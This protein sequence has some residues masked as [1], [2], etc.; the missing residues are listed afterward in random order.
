MQGVCFNGNVS[1]VKYYDPLRA[2]FQQ[3]PI[4]NV[5]ETQPNLRTFQKIVT[6]K[7]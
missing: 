1:T 6:L 7:H 2:L 5:F 3:Y 4:V